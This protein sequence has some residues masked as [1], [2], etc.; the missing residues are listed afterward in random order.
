MDVIVLYFIFEIRVF[1]VWF[2][3]I[4]EKYF[5]LSVI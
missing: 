2:K 3:E 5:F 4:D 1:L